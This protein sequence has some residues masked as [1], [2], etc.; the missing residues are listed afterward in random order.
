[1]RSLVVLDFWSEDGGDAE[2]Y[3]DDDRVR[4]GV[5]EQ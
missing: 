4:R 3:V 2:G 5:E 1:M